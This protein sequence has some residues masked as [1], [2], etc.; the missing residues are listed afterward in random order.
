MLYLRLVT[1]AAPPTSTA[2]RSD[3]LVLLAHPQHLVSAIGRPY[4]NWPALPRLSVVAKLGFF[5]T[6]E[7]LSEHV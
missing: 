5:W 7:R 6:P 2:L 1:A 4:S 3:L